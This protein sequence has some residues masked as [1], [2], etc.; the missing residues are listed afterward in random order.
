MQDMGYALEIG[1]QIMTG[2]EL[3]D[4]ISDAATTVAGDDN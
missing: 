3:I 4:S 1:N 2:E